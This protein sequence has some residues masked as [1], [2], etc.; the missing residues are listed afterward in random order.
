M[1]T[2]GPSRRQIII[3][4]N[5]ENASKVLSKLSDHVAN[6]NRLLRN[7]KS[8]T[9]ADFIRLDSRGIIVTM[10]NVAAQSDLDI[11][12]EKYIKGIDTIQ[13]DNVLSPRLPQWKS[14]LKI[15]GIPFFNEANGM[16]IKLDDVESIIK[17][18]HVFN[19]VTLASKPRVI[20]AF[21]KS[22][23]AIVRIDIWDAQSGANAKCL[24]NRS[25]NIGTYIAT[26][27]GTSIN[28]GIPQCKNYWRW[29]HTMFACC[30][31]GSKCPKCNRLHKLK[32]H[33]NIVW[34]CKPNFKINPPRLEMP[35]EIPCTHT[36][37]CANYKEEHQAN[38][39]ACSFWKHWFNCDWHNKKLQEL[40]EIRVNS[41]HWSIL[42]I[43][44]WILCKN[45]Y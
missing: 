36:F 24:I 44:A 27:W 8:N 21:P 35:K 28:P 4:M 45:D 9:A 32:H 5:S 33:Q 6:I 12:I 30:A 26:V 29:E 2:K 38:S 23:M 13:A 14:Y 41:I 3:P 31:H 43:Q 17:I 16:P 15:L 39:I 25:F 1:T 40:R 18:T 19:D 7:I 22:D 20:K 11:I 37:K 34:C 10:N 42:F